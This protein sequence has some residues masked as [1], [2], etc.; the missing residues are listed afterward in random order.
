MTDWV[1]DTV[2]AE[3]MIQP[4]D[5]ARSVRFLLDLTPACHVPELIIR[6]APA[7]PDSGA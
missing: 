6:R 7:G 4:E 5:I 1:K 2:P 3:E